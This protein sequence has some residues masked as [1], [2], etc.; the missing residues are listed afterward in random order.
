MAGVVTEFL[1]DKIIEQS[2][3]YIHGYVQ[4]N[5]LK[6]YL[7]MQ[8]NSTKK[9]NIENVFQCLCLCETGVQIFQV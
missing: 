1:A 8:D 5:C 7:L 2:Y 9:N 6:I 4:Y 3:V